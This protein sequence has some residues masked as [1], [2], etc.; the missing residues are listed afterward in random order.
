MPSSVEMIDNLVSAQKA[1]EEMSLCKEFGLKLQGSL[2]GLSGKVSL[3]AV[4]L[5]KS[6]I[7]MFD[8]VTCPN[9]LTGTDLGKLLE[10]EDILKVCIYCLY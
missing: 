7:F 9:L 1:V 6:K 2:W 4:A 8:T 3:V 10:S 5:P